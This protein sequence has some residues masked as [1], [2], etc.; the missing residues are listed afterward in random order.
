ME[1]LSPGVL[2][3]QAHGHGVVAEDGDLLGP[4]LAQ[5][6]TLAIFEVNGWDNQHSLNILT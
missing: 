4:P 6:H 2:P 5:T 1:E 3:L